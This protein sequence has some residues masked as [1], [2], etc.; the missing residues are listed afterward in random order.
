MHTE[1]SLHK[2]PTKTLDGAPIGAN[3]C[4]KHGIVSDKLFGRIF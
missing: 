4:L 2:G 1:K 3:H